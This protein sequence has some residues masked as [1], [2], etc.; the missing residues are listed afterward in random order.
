MQLAADPA[1][2]G[3]RGQ[4]VFEQCFRDGALVRCTGDTLALSPPLIIEREQI[5][6]LLEILAG[7]LRQL[8]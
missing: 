2:A 8:A 5:D 1:G 7:A 4:R 6:R 3:R